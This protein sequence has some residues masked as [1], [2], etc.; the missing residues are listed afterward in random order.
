MVLLVLVDKN[1]ACL[2]LKKF[3]EDWELQ[4]KKKKKPLKPAPKFYYLEM[5]TDH[6]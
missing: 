3:F 2:W 5:A 4:F 6:F 1:H